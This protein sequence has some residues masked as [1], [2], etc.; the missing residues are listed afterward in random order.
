MSISSLANAQQIYQSPTTQG[1]AA[2]P[3]SSTDASTPSARAHAQGSGGTDPFQKLAHDLQGA[4]LSLQGSAATPGA[5]TNVTTGLTATSN[6]DPLSQLTATMY[7][8]MG[9]LGE[10]ATTP[11]AGASASPNSG[12]PKP[13]SS[14]QNFAGAMTGDSTR[15]FQSYVSR[16]SATTTTTS[17]AGSSVQIAV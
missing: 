10:N 9:G 5:A 12:I 16:T 2:P 13:S 4:L 1:R 8:L 6:S 7:S 14:P 15:A 17:T 3:Q 11:S